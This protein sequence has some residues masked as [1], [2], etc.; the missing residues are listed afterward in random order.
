V[1][2]AAEI[3]IAQRDRYEQLWVALTARQRRLVVRALAQIEAELARAPAG[4]WT[5]A[6]SAAVL[7]QLAGAVRGLSARQL[8]LLRRALPKIAAQA[9]RDTVA[10]FETLDRDFL[11][12]AQPLRWAALEWLEGYSRPLLQSRLRIYR[13]SFARYGAETVSTIEDEVAKTV[14]FGEG[15]DTARESVWKATKHIVEDRQW[16]VDRIVRTET[17]TVYNSTTMAA[18]LEED[19]PDDPMLKKLVAVFDPVTGTDSKLLHGQ[20]RR[21]TELFTDVLRGRKFDAPPNRPNDREIVVGWR[22]S[23]GSDRSF[24]QA[25]RRESDEVVS[26]G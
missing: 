7:T 1:A 15:W 5:A 16:M 17:A 20:T 13:A 26:S 8:S 23:W 22:A 3:A 18:L 2:V 4:S 19:E 9:Q 21:V 12:A 11:G 10:W 6:R 24:D 14:L 25:T